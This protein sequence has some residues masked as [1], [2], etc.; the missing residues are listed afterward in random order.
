MS[1]AIKLSGVVTYSEEFPSLKSQDHVVLQ[2]HVT[3]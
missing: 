2:D 3:N 1:K